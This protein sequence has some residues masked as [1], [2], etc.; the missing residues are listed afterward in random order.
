MS[1]RQHYEILVIGSGKVSGLDDG[2]SRKALHNRRSGILF[3]VADDAAYIAQHIAARNIPAGVLTE[4][5]QA[6]GAQE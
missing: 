3:G 5:W 6:L 4:L 1:K 2:K